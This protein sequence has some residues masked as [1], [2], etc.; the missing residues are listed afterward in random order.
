[1]D[2]REREPVMSTVLGRSGSLVGLLAALALVGCADEARSGGGN[3]PGEEGG[4]AGAAGGGTG[5]FAGSGGLGGTG[6]SAGAGGTG[7][8]A[9][10]GGAP[11]KSC[12]NSLDCVGEGVCGPEKVCVDCVGAAD[13]PDN[14]SCVGNECRPRC[15]SDLDCVGSGLLCD[16][17]NGYCVE[18]LVHADCKTEQHCA[19]GNCRADLCVGGSRA[20]R[21]GA[22]VECSEAGDAF[23]SSSPCWS[24]QTCVESEGEA[25]CADW[26][27]TAGAVE[28]MANKVVTCSADGL[29]VESVVSCRAEQ[30]CAG[31]ACQEGECAPSERTCKTDGV[32]QCAADG[33]SSTLVYSCGGGQYCDDSGEATCKTGVCAPDQPACDGNNAA[34]CNGNGSGYS[35]A[36]MDCGARVCARGLCETPVCATAE[37][38]C[39]SGDVYECASDRLHW[40]RKQDCASGTYCDA[41]SLACKRW[42]CTPSEPVCDGNVARTCNGSGSGYLAGGTDCA[43]GTVCSTG[44]CVLPGT[45]EGPSCAGGLDC[46]G[47]SCCKSIELPGGTYQMGRSA[48]SGASD[49]YSRGYFNEL[50]EHPATVAGFSL[51]K[52]EVTV[53]RF[54]KFVAQYTGAAPA[55][56]EGAHPLIAGTGWQSAWNVS[57]STSQAALKTNLACDESYQTW[58]DS[59]S[60]NERH[61]INCVSWYEAMAFCIWDGGRLPTEAEW[62]YAA[63]G[64]SEN[65]LYPWGS[66]APDGTRANFSEGANTPYTDVGSTPRGE[67]RWGQSDL[68]G[69]MWEWAYDGY[70]ALWYGKNNPCNNCAGIASGSNRVTRG[71]SW[72][73]VATSLRAAIRHDVHPTKRNDIIGFRCARSAP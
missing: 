17:V 2:E 4:A 35:T 44:I 11:S 43:A 61:A 36:G 71:G 1:M 7:G 47:V 15:D 33:L 27:C 46:G 25:R 67:G 8:S 39:Q 65:R 41:G 29:A 49:Y 73:Y 5:G 66:Q 19:S 13:C 9:G 72:F 21:D 14:Q 69:G 60:A 55:A 3:R 52:Y 63:A 58:T 20:C 53:G 68:S 56:G 12:A 70:D 28:C 23:G 42:V 22:V 18:C 26:R 54:R 38:R 32:Y 24:R 16:R 51:D 62:E 30:V 31:G 45:E 6:G 34:T 59:V 10:T 50:P 40:T 57:L 48:V 37:R 64:G